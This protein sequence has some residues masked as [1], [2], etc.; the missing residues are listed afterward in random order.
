MSPPPA[1]KAQIATTPNATTES[2]TKSA[3][4]AVQAPAQPAT[5][6]AGAQNLG[7]LRILVGDNAGHVTLLNKALTTLGTPGVQ[8]SVITKRPHGYF[9]SHVDGKKMPLLNGQAIGVQAQA[10][11]D[12]DVIDLEDIKMEFYIV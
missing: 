5:S 8:V 4:L 7:H 2:D 3:A 10:L 12:H 1:V 6:V 11:S 9:I